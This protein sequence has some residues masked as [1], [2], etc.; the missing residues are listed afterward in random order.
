MNYYVE[1][2]DKCHIRMRCAILLYLVL[3]YRAPPHEIALNQEENL[4]YVTQFTILA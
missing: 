3:I 2:N 4:M 1:K